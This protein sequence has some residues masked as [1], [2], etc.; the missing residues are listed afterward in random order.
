MDLEVPYARRGVYGMTGEDTLAFLQDRGL[1]VMNVMA[2]LPTTKAAAF[3]QSMASLLTGLYSGV[4]GHLV[5]RDSSYNGC[6]AAL[7]SVPPRP[8]FKICTVQ[9]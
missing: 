4:K 2:M 1:F 8:L 5:V 3:K 6:N 9:L 7:P